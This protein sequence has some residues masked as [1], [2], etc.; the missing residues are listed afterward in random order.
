MANRWGNNG[1]SDRFY[2]LG[3]QNHLN[4]DCS[5]KI[6]RYLLHGKKAMTNLDSI[7]KSRDTTLPTKLCLVK[8]M[9]FPTVMY[10]C[11]SWTTK[12]A[13]RLKNWYFWTVVCWR[14]LLRVPWVAR[15]SNQSILKEINP[16]YSLERLML[17][18]K[19]QYLT[20]DMKSQPVGKDPDAGKD[21]G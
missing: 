8:T 5:H 20:T 1:N 18:L 14:R 12:N 3:L 19:L 10:G 7:S 16:A 9:V 17:K 11:E 2:F 15:W 4:G 13:E 21:S 6:K